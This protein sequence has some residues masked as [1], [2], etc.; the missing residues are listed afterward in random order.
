MKVTN[1]L[2]GCVLVLW[3]FTAQAGD[4]SAGQSASVVC[5]ACHSS[6]GTPGKSA[7]DTFPN[8]AGQKE[9]YLVKQLKAFRSGERVDATMQPMATSL[10]D[11]DIEN[12]AAYFAS[13][14]DS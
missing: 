14:S 10:T 7:V 13:L 3:G 5:A 1:M 9:G 12:L 2:C 11:S 6:S 8:L 4:I